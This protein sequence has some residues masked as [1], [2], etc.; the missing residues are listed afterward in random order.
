MKNP[1][2]AKADV[3]PGSAHEPQASSLAGMIPMPPTLPPKAAAKTCTITVRVSREFKDAVE[4]A[5][6]RRNMNNTQ[7]VSF[8]LERLVEEDARM[9]AGDG[10]TE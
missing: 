9:I 4:A 7:L 10:S 6:R 8:L 2:G 3:G 1:F 5:A